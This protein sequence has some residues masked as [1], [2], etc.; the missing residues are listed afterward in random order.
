[1]AAEVRFRIQGI[2]I[3]G[4][5]LE[6]AT[7]LSILAE[8]L[9]ASSWDSWDATAA[10]VLVASNTSP[11][12]SESVSKQVTLHF[13]WPTVAVDVGMEECL[14]NR[15]FRRIAAVA[16][17]ATEIQLRQGNLRHGWSRGRS[18]LSHLPALGAGPAWMAS[19]R[20]KKFHILSGVHL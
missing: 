10:E 5:C 11:T 9:P 18:K 14:R 17:S 2:Q 4:R 13:A 7:F 6:F 20:S 15:S 3:A 1:V 8:T 16:L 12:S 19:A